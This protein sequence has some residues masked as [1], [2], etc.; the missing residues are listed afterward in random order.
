MVLSEPSLIVVMD[1]I[2]KQSGDTCELTGIYWLSG[3]GHAAYIDIEVGAIF[4]NC[5]VCGKEIVWKLR[6]FPSAQDSL[7]DSH[8][9]FPPRG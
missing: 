7:F 1:K 5:E 3:C 9:L 4:P 8:P 2:I 6:I